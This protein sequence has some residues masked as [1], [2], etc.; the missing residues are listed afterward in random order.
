MQG[1]MREEVL[2]EVQALRDRAKRLDRTKEVAKLV[3]SA[4][5]GAAVMW[6]ALTII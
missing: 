2:R 1:A 4:C 5:A 6:V 3:G